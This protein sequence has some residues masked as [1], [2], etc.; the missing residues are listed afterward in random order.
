MMSD[1]DIG[2]DNSYSILMYRND[3]IFFL[4]SLRKYMD[5]SIQV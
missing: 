4:D 2:D 5:C 1:S 3:A